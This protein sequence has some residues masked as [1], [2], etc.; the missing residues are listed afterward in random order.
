MR[1]RTLGTVVAAVGLSFLF[2]ACGE[3][4][5]GGDGLTQ[6]AEVKALSL[7]LDGPRTKISQTSSVRM[8]LSQV[9][10]GTSTFTL[11]GETRF[12]PDNVARMTMT[13]TPE[14]LSQAGG[15]MVA[16][17]LITESIVTPSVM[18]MNLGPEAAAKNG[19]PWVKLDPAEMAKVDKTGAVQQYQK[20]AEQ[21]SEGQQDPVAHLALLQKSGDIREIGK[22]TV[23]G[24][25]TTHYAGTVDLKVLQANNA[26]GMGLKE[27]DFEQ[28]NKTFKQFG[29]KTADI[30][31]WIGGDQLPVK[32]TTGI[33]VKAQGQSADV[34]TT[35]EYLGWN[36]DVDV[37]PPPADQT[38]S[39]ADLAAQG[40][41]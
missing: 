18:Y 14:F 37:T 22:E 11:E 9:I 29:V 40:K 28:L 13:F 38:V 30:D 19:E 27:K 34:T 1:K 36:V 31:L 12:R 16:A 24:K 5:S 10:D 25:P 8:R 21:G 4:K 3:E 2:T 41:V 26:A 39:I 35:V 17:P 23:N 15:R 33:T 32:Q 6:S 20:M 7:E